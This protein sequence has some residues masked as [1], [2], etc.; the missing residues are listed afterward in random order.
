MPHFKEYIPSCEDYFFKNKFDEGM[1][2]YIKECYEITGI[3]RSVGKLSNMPICATPNKYTG[4]LVVMLHITASSLVFFASR[5]LSH[6]NEI[7]FA[8]TLILAIYPF[9]YGAVTWAIGSY[10]ISCLIWFLSALIL[11]MQCAENNNKK[12]ILKAAFIFLFSFLCCVN[13]EHLVFAVPLMGILAIAW[14]GDSILNPKL[15]LQ[16]WAT[17]PIAAFFLYLILVLT[18]QSGAGLMDTRGNDISLIEN[19]NL[20]T[21]ISVWAHQWKNILF[22]QPL[23]SI[24]AITAFFYQNDLAN[25]ISGLILLLLGVVLVIKSGSAKFNNTSFKVNSSKES[26]AITVCL[27]VSMMLAVS[28]VHAIAGGYS[29]SARHQYIP[30]ALIC[31]F[32]ASIGKNLSHYFLFLFNKK[33]TPIILLCVLGIVSNWIILSINNYET[34]TYDAICNYLKNEKPFNEF[35]IKLEPP[36]F[37][38]WP[39]MKNTA[40]ADFYLSEYSI[41]HFL[42]YHKAET[43]R[44]VKSEESKNTIVIKRNLNSIQILK[45][46]GL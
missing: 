15:L 22:F 34:K 26:D 7:A 38:L 40:S 31:M 8:C 19:I 36:Y 2:A 14:R 27:I 35:S 12:N 32:L 11:S 24:E 4:L 45:N 42:K 13:N 3:R 28:S 20:P 29:V 30:I 21:I 25:I 33:K 5:R 16:Y 39:N 18:T 43:I 9:T 6:S 37:H 46:H 44:L 23:F 1:M 17:A 10:I 41:N